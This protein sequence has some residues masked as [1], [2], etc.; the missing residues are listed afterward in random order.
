MAWRADVGW[1]G[2]QS[3]YCPRRLYR[4][5]RSKPGVL[6]WCGNRRRGGLVGD[7]D[8][9]RL[10]RGRPVRGQP[11][12]GHCVLSHP[13]VRY[14]YR[15]GERHGISDSVSYANCHAH[16]DSIGLPDRHA[17]TQ[18]I[19]GVAEPIQAV[20]DAHPEAVAHSLRHAERSAVPDHVLPAAARHRRLGRSGLRTCGADPAKHSRAG[21]A[22][23]SE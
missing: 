22:I 10:V 14:R 1:H 23:P 5:R 2:P 4:L 19:D 20:T 8:L 17:V 3:A 13:V 16:A 15:Y 6:V 9:G 18:P 12:A 7:R 21:R 11:V